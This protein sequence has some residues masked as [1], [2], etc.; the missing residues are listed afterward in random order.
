MA[1][2]DDYNNLTGGSQSV[3]KVIVF[4]L[5]SIIFINSFVLPVIASVGESTETEYNTGV[6]VS[7]ISELGYEEQMEEFGENAALAL[8]SKGLSIIDTGGTSQPIVLISI[9]NFDPTYPIAIINAG[10][11]FPY[12]YNMMTYTYNVDTHK[13]VYTSYYTSGTTLVAYLYNPENGV[14][15]QDPNGKHILTDDEIHTNDLSEITG[16]GVSY[17]QNVIYANTEQAFVQASGIPWGEVTPTVDVDTG[18]Y[19]TVNSISYQNIT[20][21]YYIGPLYATYT[22]N[23]LEGTPVGELINTIPT[24][25]IIGVVL[26]IIRSIKRNE[27]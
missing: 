18:E 25:I 23:T 8:T 10:K 9:D 19:D 21:D 5:V 26:Y 17:Q 12:K 15:I 13:Y 27:E 24:L 11:D 6:R 16:Y 3:I 2:E 7:E 22:T 4:A 14:W 1:E 20:C